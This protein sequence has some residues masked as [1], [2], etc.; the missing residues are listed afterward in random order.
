MDFDW[1]EC[2]EAAFRIWW[3][4]HKYFHTELVCMLVFI[5]WK[6]TFFFAWGDEFFYSAWPLMPFVLECAPISHNIKPAAMTL[7]RGVHVDVHVFQSKEAHH[8][9]QIWIVGRG[10]KFSVIFLSSLMMMV[11]CW[12]KEG[13]VELLGLL[14]GLFGLISIYM[15]FRVSKQ[16]I[17]SV[18]TT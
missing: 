1:T 6:K 12:C 9:H 13:C 8:I 3:H 15:N 18:A 4:P 2:N 10:L 7:G 16:S 14:G 17:T 5:S 11:V